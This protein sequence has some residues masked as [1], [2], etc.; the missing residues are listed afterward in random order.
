V[1]SNNFAGFR[2]A[3]GD[4][5]TVASPQGR[6]HAVGVLREFSGRSDPLSLLY[7]FASLTT[8]SLTGTAVSPWRLAGPVAAGGR[9]PRFNTPDGPGRTIRTITVT[10]TGGGTAVNATA[11][12]FVVN[13]V[14]TLSNSGGAL[15]AAVNSTTDYFVTTTTANTFTISASVGGTAITFATAG[16]GTQSA[17]LRLGYWAGLNMLTESFRR[18]IDSTGNTNLLVGADYVL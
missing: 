11:H 7:S 5:L 3:L 16:T 2:G 18:G 17:A 6:F 4:G 1:A 12:P 15:P 13:D 9:M 8:R 14:L 10:F